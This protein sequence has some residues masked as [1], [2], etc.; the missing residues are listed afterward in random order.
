MQNEPGIPNKLA[1]KFQATVAVVIVHYGKLQNT[2]KC[3]ESLLKNLYHSIEIIVISNE[4]QTL[5]QLPKD[6][7]IHLNVLEYNRGFSAANNVGV[8]IAHQLKASYIFFLNNDASIEPDCIQILIK[9]METHPE[10]SAA[11]PKVMIADDLNRPLPY[12]CGGI[13]AWYRLYPKEN[14]NKAEPVPIHFISG[15]AFFIRTEVLKSVGVWDEDYFL[16]WEDTDLSWRLI[17]AG[18][19]PVSI[20]NALATHHPAQ[21]TGYLSKTYVYF[22]TRNNLLFI[23]KHTT[24][25]LNKLCYLIEFFIRRCVCS[26]WKLL[27]AGK[28]NVLPM[29]FFGIIDFFYGITGPGRL[30]KTLNATAVPD[31]H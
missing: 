20:P 9:Y 25:S 17:K 7:R 24:Q 13:N 31:K 27:V 15:C 11:T 21:S 14:L 4:P 22:M 28:I 10:F 12:S 8:R 18:F 1:E 6:P 2:L 5:L 29:I 30:T 16:Y 3:V 26:L 19:K 23:K